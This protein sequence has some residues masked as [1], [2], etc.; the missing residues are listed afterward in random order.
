MQ[1]LPDLT[2]FAPRTLFGRGRLSALPAL[3]LEWGH[4][5]LLACGSSFRGGPLFA[6]LAGRLGEGCRVVEHPGGEP[7]VEQAEALRAL[8]RGHRADWIAA[9]GGG[10]VLDLAK[11]AA[12]LFNETAPVADFHAGRAVG[13]AGLPFLA[14]PTTAGTGAEATP[15]AVLTDTRTALK[16]SIRDDRFMARAV[17][18]DGA[19]LAGTPAAV[20]AHAGMDAYTQALEAGVSRKSTAWSEATA[21]AAL[22][23]IAA[24]LPAVQADPAAPAADSLLAGSYLAGVALAQARLGVVHGLA[25]PLGAFYHQPHGLVCAVCLPAALE[26]NRPALGKAYDRFSEAAGGDLTAV[27]SGLI[28]RLGIKNPFKGQPIIRLEEIVEQTLSSGS[29][30]A[31]PKAIGRA[32]VEWLLKKVFSDR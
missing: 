20:V 16:K 10:S 4:R 27:T 30:Q 22:R 25:H 14:V 11:A 3:S 32:E 29:T 5:G 19:L 23:L 2:L 13:K 8:A 17:I 12:G 28:A 7:T 31:N 9:V 1:A 18:L 26:L 21:L 15:N 6:G 24:S